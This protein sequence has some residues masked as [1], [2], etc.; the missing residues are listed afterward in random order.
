MYWKK[1]YFHLCC[2]S[3]EVCEMTVPIC[4]RCMSTSKYHRIDGYGSLMHCGLVSC[5]YRRVCSPSHIFVSLLMIFTTNLGHLW[6]LCLLS[7][8]KKHILAFIL[9]GIY[10]SLFI[11]YSWLNMKDVSPVP[12]TVLKVFFFFEVGSETQ[13]ALKEVTGLQVISAS[14]DM[15]TKSINFGKSLVSICVCVTW[16]FHHAPAQSGNLC[17]SFWFSSQSFSISCPLTWGIAWWHVFKKSENCLK[18][19]ASLGWILGHLLTVCN[20]IWLRSNVDF[21]QMMRQKYIVNIL[22]EFYVEDTQ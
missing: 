14:I 22:E 6:I 10:C 3:F 2:N 21:G 5:N 9:V 20:N 11:F 8:Q 4:T 15:V 12:F 17:T 18:L 13:R 1:K 16:R 7:L 19:P